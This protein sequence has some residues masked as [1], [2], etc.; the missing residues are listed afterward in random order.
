MTQNDSLAP[1]RDNIFKL[2]RIWLSLPAQL[3]GR[4]SR[5]L[6]AL[7]ITDEQIHELMVIKSQ[8]EFAKRFK[9]ARKT[10]Y[11]WSQVPLSDDEVA[12]DWRQWAKRLSRNVYWSLYEK[13]VEEGDAQR[14]KL[15]AQLVGDFPE[16]NGDSKPLTLVD[17][18]HA[19]QRG[20]TVELDDHWQG[21]LE[22]A[23][24]NKAKREHRK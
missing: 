3:R 16:Y 7:G 1:Y 19:E 23:E 20:E 18:Y 8:S 22:A 21:L 17:L 4:T 9:V 6:A 13:A 10:L 12:L 11:R 2:Y 14:V 15:W 24:A 5:E